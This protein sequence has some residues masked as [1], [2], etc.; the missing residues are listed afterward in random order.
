MLL[1]GRGHLLVEVIVL[2]HCGSQVSTTSA[3]E[4]T[5]GLTE[6]QLFQ[7]AAACLG[8]QE[9]DNA[10]FDKDP[11]TVDGK[12]L[13]LDGVERN[14]VDVGGEKTAKLAKDLLDTNTTTTVIVRPELDQVR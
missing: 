13:P 10:E 4:R 2:E 14:G 12:I 9:V 11:A 8:V 1:N 7:S 3:A 5:I 6:G